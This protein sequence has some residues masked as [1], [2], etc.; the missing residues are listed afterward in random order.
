MDDQIESYSP[1]TLVQCRI[2]HDEDEDLNMDT[3]CSCCGTLKARIPLLIFS[4][5]FNREHII[6]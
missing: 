1:N 5:F 6:L 4:F 3:P 2:C